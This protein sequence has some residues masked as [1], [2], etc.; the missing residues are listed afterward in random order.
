MTELKECLDEITE[1]LEQE[2]IPFWEQRTVDKECGGYFTNFDANGILQ[3]DKTKYIVTQ[4]RML[5]GFSKL[6]RTYQK[7]EYLAIAKQGFVFLTTYFWDKEYGGWYWKTS[8]KGSVIDDGKV[9][10]GQTFAIYALSEYVLAS[11][12]VEAKSYAEETFELLQKYC[13]DTR[14]GGYFEN[15]ERDFSLSQAGYAGGDVKSLDIHMHIMESFTTLYECT[16]KH[17]HAEKLKE[18]IELIVTRMVSREIGCGYNQF[19]LSFEPRPE[20]LI[21]RTWNDE[22]KARE[23]IKTPFNTTSYGHNVELVWLLHHADQILGENPHRFDYLT[24]SMF[25]HLCQ[26]GYDNAVGGVFCEGPWE[27][28]ALVL[29]KEWWQNCET[30]VGLLDAYEYVKDEKYLEMFVQ[31]WNFASTYFINHE[32]GEWRQLLRRDGTSITEELGNAWKGIYHTGRAMIECKK[33]LQKI[34]ENA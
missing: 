6:Y 8:Q 34:L 18:V 26:Y 17:K 22:R 21:K 3:E 33:R 10:Y 12:S 29:D 31:T 2:L 13:A 16:R 9:V 19:T 30:L 25:K 7:P 28:E 24:Q 23:K 32:V 11:G 27:G 4:T 14:S 1:H 20:M 5:W 15:M